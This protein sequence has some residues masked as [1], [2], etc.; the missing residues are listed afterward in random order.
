MRDQSTS[1]RARVAQ[2]EQMTFCLS[3]TPVMVPQGDGS[4]LVRPGKPV[5]E[6]TPLQA[7][8]MLQISRSAVYELLNAGVLP[9]RR[10]LRRKILIPSSAIED[11]KRRTADPEFWASN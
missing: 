3:F 7:S 5:A 10:P 2:V 1:Q 8:R 9:H 4:V 6:V 11:W